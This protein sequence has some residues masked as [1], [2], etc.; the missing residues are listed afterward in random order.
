M[1]ASEGGS[2][3][4]RLGRSRRQRAAAEDSRPAMVD[5]MGCRCWV[6]GCSWDIEFLE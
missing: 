4:N 5:S 6:E 3:A 2:G 1:E